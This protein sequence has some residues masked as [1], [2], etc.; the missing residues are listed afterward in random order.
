MPLILTSS[1]KL[2][3]W[4]ALRQAHEGVLTEQ[5][6]ACRARQ[7]GIYR[8]VND[9][10]Q[11]LLIAEFTELDQGNEFLQVWL[12]VCSSLCNDI[13]NHTVWEALGWTAIP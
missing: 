11:V 6:K 2:K 1:F 8:N 7:Y 3:D 4:R 9:A 13:P 5:A 10:T 12:E